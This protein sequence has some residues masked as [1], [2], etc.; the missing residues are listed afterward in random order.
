MATRAYHTLPKKRVCGF[1][2]PYS[3]LS[4]F[5]REPDG[6]CVEVEYQRAKCAEFK[7]RQIFDRMIEKGTITPMQAKAMGRK[8]KLRDDWEDVKVS[9]MIF[10]VTKK[11][12]DHNDLRILLEMTGDAH[13][14]ETNTWGDRFWGV[15]QGEGQNVLGDIL[16]QVRS[17]L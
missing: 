8:V 1:F 15:C 6:S 11:F 2:G 16:M 13:L 7:D 9:I 14:E 4:N 3:Y 5:Y 12:R 10:Y 17:E